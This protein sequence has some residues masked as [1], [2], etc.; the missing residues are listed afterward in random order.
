MTKSAPSSRAPCAILRSSPAVVITRAVKQLRNLDGGDAHARVRAQH[1]YG[2]AGADR[3]ASGKHVPRCDEDQ[4]DAG[5][6]VEIERIGDRD[7]VGAGHGDQF[8][9]AAVDRIAE[10]GE[11]AALILQSGKA[12]RA[13]SAK[14]NGRDQHALAGFEIR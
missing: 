4:G 3:G 11:L 8:A 6:L 13:V 10:D 9:V 2:L 14:V 1:Q 5:G 7:H 12:F